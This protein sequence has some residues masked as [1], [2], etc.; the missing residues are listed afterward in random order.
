[1][2]LNSQYLEPSTAAL[3]HAA[4]LRGYRGHI[5]LGGLFASVAAEDLLEKIP[6][7]DTI[8]HFEGELTYPEMREA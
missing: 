1:M 5:T 7:I 6:G 3:I 2:N 8:V 4:R